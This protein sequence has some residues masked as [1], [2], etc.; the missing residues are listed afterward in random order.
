M[1]NDKHEPSSRPPYLR[2]YKSHPPGATCCRCDE[3]ISNND[4]AAFVPGLNR[5]A[6]AHRTCLPPEQAA[7]DR[8]ASGTID[9][10]RPRHTGGRE[11][12][13]PRE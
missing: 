4:A 2:L 9:A 12:E 3:P 6:W 11:P 1:T 10:H 7:E 13:I 5:G 8:D